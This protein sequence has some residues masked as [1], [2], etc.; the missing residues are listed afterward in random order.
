MTERAPAEGMAAGARTLP[1]PGRGV[2]HPALVFAIAASLATALLVSLGGAASAHFLLNVNIRIF[3]VVHEPDRIRLLV[4]LPMPWLVADKLGPETA[5]GTRAPAPYTTNRIEDGAL[6]H[7]L[8]V[9]AL[10]R[11]PEGLAGILAGGLVLEVGGETLRADVGR[12]RA[13]PAREQ[14]P[15]ARRDE[16]EAALSGPVYPAEFEVTYAGD[17]VVDVELIYPIHRKAGGYTLRS[18]LDPGLPDQGETANLVL[19]HATEPPLVFRVRGLMAEPVDVSFSVLKA[20]WTFLEEGVRHILEGTDHVLFVLCLV[21]GATAAGALAWRITGFTVGHS[22]TLSLGLFGYVPEGA[23]FIP[24]VETGIALSILY[25]AAVALA[26]TGHRITIAITALLGLLHGLGFSFVL[27]E[28]LKLEAPNLWQSLLAFNVGIEIGQ[29]LIALA[30]W[31]IL[32]LIANR[33]PERIALVRW[34]VALPCILVAT[35]WTGERAMQFF[36]SL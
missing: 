7:Y 6:V 10:R 12:V 27:K 20:A 14:A 33:L 16:A 26:S 4:R 36:S 15:F 32:V 13:S 8:D 11:S 23:W 35:V 1:A 29:L 31:P 2:A 19:D 18:T 24:L 21:L 30:I 25:A 9:D 5:A 3:H 34:A 28:I 17:T 22:V